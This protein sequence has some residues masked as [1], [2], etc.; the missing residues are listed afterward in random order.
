MNKLHCYHINNR[1]SCA[2]YCD[3]KP[4]QFIMYEVYNIMYFSTWCKKHV[5]VYSSNFTVISEEKYMKLMLL[6]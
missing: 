2:K 3:N 1:N 4:V 6:L 5:R